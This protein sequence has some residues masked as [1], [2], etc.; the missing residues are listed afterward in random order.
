MPETIRQKLVAAII[1]TLGQIR[2]SNGYQTDVGAT[3]L[4]FPRQVQ[5]T[6]GQDELPVLGVFDVDSTTSRENLNARKFDRVLTI[7]IRAY[8]KK[9][10]PGPEIR[11]IIGDIETAIGTNPRWNGLAMATMPA[12]EGVVIQSED[13]EI[14]AAAVEVTILYPTCAFNPYE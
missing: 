6:Y 12:R 3:V 9:D 14:S 11:K 8:L 2:V 4:D 13:F 7:Q 5:A 10:T 1:T